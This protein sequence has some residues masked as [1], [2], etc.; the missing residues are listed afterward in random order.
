MPAFIDEKSEPEN[1][2][3][4]WAYRVTIKNKGDTPIQ[5]LRRRWEISDSSGNTEIVEGEGVV[6]EQPIIPV[7]EFYEYTSGCPLR[8]SSGIMVGEFYAKTE[9]GKELTISIPAFSLD[10]PDNDPVYN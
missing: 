6:G 7:G 2:Q 4:F 5:I 10:L 1:N 8:T 3:Y 9:D